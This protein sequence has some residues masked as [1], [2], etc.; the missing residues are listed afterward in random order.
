VAWWHILV[1]ILL[2]VLIWK[3]GMAVLRAISSGAPRERADPEDVGELDVFHVCAE[4][5]TEYRVTRLGTLQVP[6]HCGEPM[7]VVRRPASAP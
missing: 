7:R 4:C 6:R 1:A 2:A 5:G 3:V